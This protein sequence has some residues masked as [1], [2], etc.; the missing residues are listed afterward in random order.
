MKVSK[1][2]MFYFYIAVC[3]IYSG[4]TFFAVKQFPEQIKSIF[5]SHGYFV[6]AMTVLFVILAASAGAKLNELRHE[7]EKDPLKAFC[8][9]YH[10][11]YTTFLFATLYF[12]FNSAVLSVIPYTISNVLTFCDLRLNI[13]IAILVMTFF[14]KKNGK[15]AFM[16]KILVYA[17]ASALIIFELAVSDIIT[18]VLMLV[19]N[20]LGLLNNRYKTADKITAAAITAAAILTLLIFVSGEWLIAAVSA[21]VISVIFLNEKKYIINLFHLRKGAVNYET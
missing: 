19:I 11:I 4:A 18:L 3:F 10:V 16:K 1:K 5:S 14:L 7:A 9:I 15:S 13:P 2:T 8:V 17:V 12:L 20:N 6:S 21:A